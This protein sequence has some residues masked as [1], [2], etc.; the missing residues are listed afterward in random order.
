MLDVYKSRARLTSVARERLS[1]RFTRLHWALSDRLEQ[2]LLR[3]RFAYDRKRGI[4]FIEDAF[5][6]CLLNCPLY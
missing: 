6:R 5:T 2:L 1:L 4:G 3:G